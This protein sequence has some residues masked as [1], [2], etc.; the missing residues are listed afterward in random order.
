MILFG[1]FGTFRTFGLCS[2]RSE[3]CSEATLLET[4]LLH[5]PEESLPVLSVISVLF[6]TMLE[7]GAVVQETFPTD[8][9]HHRWRCN[10]KLQV[11]DRLFNTVCRLFNTILHLSPICRHSVSCQ[12][13]IFTALI[14]WKILLASMAQAIRHQSEDGSQEHG[15][16]PLGLRDD[17]YV[18]VK[19]KHSE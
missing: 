16:L 12:L 7:E 3:Q 9:A 8:P 15:P 19:S 5:P 17:K 11:L 14:F 4:I 18:A 10:C 2:D 6:P 1:T 13:H